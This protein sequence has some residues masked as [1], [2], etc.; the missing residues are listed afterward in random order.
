MFVLFIA[1]AILVRV[2]SNLKEAKKKNMIVRNRL[3]TYKQLLFRMSTITKVSF[4]GKYK[5]IYS[6]PTKLQE[7]IIKKPGVEP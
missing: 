3:K 1:L 4:T 7:E 2:K 6:K 5:P